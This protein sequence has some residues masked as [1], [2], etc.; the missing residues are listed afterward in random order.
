MRTKFWLES[1][2]GDHFS[3]CRSGELGRRTCGMVYVKCSCMFRFAFSVNRAY[4]HICLSAVIFRE[5]ERCVRNEAGVLI[6]SVRFSQSLGGNT[7]A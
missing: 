2:K 7:E 3:V 4:L 6:P 1:L 5:A